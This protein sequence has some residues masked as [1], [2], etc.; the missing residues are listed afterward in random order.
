MAMYS[1]SW[2][3][4]TFTATADGANLVD[5]TYAAYLQGG[6]STQQLKINEIYI[7]GEDTATTANTIVLGRDSTVK[8][9]T[10]GGGFTALLDGS[11]TAAATVAVAGNTAGTTKPQRSTTLHL[12]QL[13]MNSFGGI[14]RWVV[15]QGATVSV[16][17]NTASLGEVS[18]SSVTGAG[19]TSGH[20]IFEV[21]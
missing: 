5:S 4:V 9:G 6:T 7:G 12:L 18:L 13:T 8:T 19:K 20:I 1:Q 21:V 11:A 14:C 3:T 10:T 15:P 16:V 17:G 2:Q